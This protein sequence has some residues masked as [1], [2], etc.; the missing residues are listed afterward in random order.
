MNSYEGSSLLNHMQCRLILII[1]NYLLI[2]IVGYKIIKKKLKNMIKIFDIV[3]KLLTSNEYDQ[4][5]DKDLIYFN[6]IMMLL[7][8]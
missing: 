8:Y 5:Y 6:K 7:K 3:L 1:K 4:I 2:I